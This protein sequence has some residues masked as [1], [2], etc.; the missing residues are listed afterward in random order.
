M[1][2]LALVLTLACINAY[3]LPGTPPAVQR[4]EVGQRLS[5]NIPPM[6]AAMLERLG[7]YQNT[8]GASCEPP[9]NCP[10]SPQ[11]LTTFASQTDHGR[12]RS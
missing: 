9:A 1:R 6:P 2:R 12:Q 5:E 4:E 11:R 7:R 8:R 10:P 3:A